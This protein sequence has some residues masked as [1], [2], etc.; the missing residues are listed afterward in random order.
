MI[1]RLQEPDFA[2]GRHDL[3]FGKAAVD[4]VFCGRPSDRDG[5]ERH[6]VGEVEALAR[7]PAGDDPDDEAEDHGGDGSARGGPILP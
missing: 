4:G 1:D 6:L 5:K 7:G 3:P 2:D